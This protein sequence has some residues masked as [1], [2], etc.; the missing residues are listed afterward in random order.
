MKRWTWIALVLIAVGLAAFWVIKDR[1]QE[2]KTPPKVPVEKVTLLNPTGPTVVP[3]APLAAGKITGDLTVEVQ[4]W[5]TNDEAVAALASNK[6]EFAVLP[7]APAANI[8]AND[9]PL[10]LLGIHEWKVFYMVAAGQ[11]TFDGFESLAGQEIYLPVGRGTTIDILLRSALLKSGLDP[12]QDVKLVY[13]PPQEI[14]ALFNAGKV[15][16]AALPE[17]FVTMTISGGK[18]RIVVD[19]QEYYGDLADTK[20][21]IPIA[22]LFVK[23]SFFAEHPEET[24]EL[25]RQF[26]A[27]LDWYTNNTDEAVDLSQD[28]L[29]VPKPVVLKSLDRAEFYWEPVKQC[30]SEVETFLAKMRE[31]YPEGIKQLPTKGFYGE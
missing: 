9:I 18:G 21:R 14:V 17:P 31:L 16:Y 11:Q 25:I 26:E 6:A 24:A 30:R 5:K 23:T 28:V 13:S 19:F 12:E 27:S 3:L 8:Q 2:E 1:P 15:V 22:G 10:T 4:Y 7:L 20:P 29:P